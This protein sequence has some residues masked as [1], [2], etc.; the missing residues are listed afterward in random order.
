[1]I[2]RDV[3]TAIAAINGMFTPAEKKQEKTINR[4]LNTFT[5]VTKQDELLTKIFFRQNISFGY[6][7]W[8]GI[9]DLA[10]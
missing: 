8:S 4:F 9:F 1:M 2:V 3:K 10:S 6:R 5:F 7:V